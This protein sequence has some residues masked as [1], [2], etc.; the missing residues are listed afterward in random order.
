MQH[1]VDYWQLAAGL[2]LFLFGM[3]LLEVS[4]SR[5]AGR[6]FKQFLKASTAG[7]LRGVLAGAVATAA[8]Q[9]SSVV[10]LIVLAFVGSS[11]ID[12][13]AAIAIVFGSNVGTTVTGW[14]VATVGFKLDIEA[15]AL[16]LV[17]AGGLAVVWSGSAPRLRQSGLLLS[18]FGLM[19]LGLDYMKVGAEAAQHWFDPAA[20]AG[21]PLFAFLAV[22]IVIA[23]VVQSSSATV[24]LALSALYAGIIELDAA[25]AIA[26]GADLG[27]T[28]TAVL[29]ALAGS[30]DKKR[31]ALAIFIFN[32]ITN[33]LTFVLLEPLL[34]V[35]QTVLGIRDPLYALVA[36]HSLFNTLGVV[37]FLPLITALS[38]WLSSRFV[39][40]GD[41]LLRHIKPG[42]TAI[43]EAAVESVG[44]ETLR[45]IDQAAALNLAVFGLPPDH[46]LYAA[47]EDRRNV[48][49]FAEKPDLERG[50]ASLKALEGEI[51]AYALELQRGTLDPDESGRIGR[52]VP[53]L[54]NAVHSV[55]SVRD[56]QHDLERF[57]DS[58]SDRFY[59]Y[60]GQFRESVRDFYEAASRVNADDVVAVRFENLVKLKQV[61]RQSHDLMHRRIYGE[62]ERGDLRRDE[63]STLLNVNRELYS[64]HLSLVAA[65]ADVLLD[66]EGAEDFASLPVSG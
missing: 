22:G 56:V 64:A 63:I 61:L 41:K 15:L 14:I 32:I 47:D 29:G 10:S 12:L 19:L 25:A 8:L 66:E 59:A 43:P 57:R 17:A 21:Y 53:A 44:K 13:P 35:V 11:L 9:S 18:G 54:R 3:H 31:V 46:R 7:P 34:D 62:I 1:S 2:G 42:I 4:L 38:R 55:K 28:V 20:M 58:V 33:T 36:F 26:I 40:P 16:P 23:A 50:Y 30:D 39:D 65:L 45:L 37:L 27:T 52:L 51:L 6:P 60:L 49:A 5:L 48:E 24:M